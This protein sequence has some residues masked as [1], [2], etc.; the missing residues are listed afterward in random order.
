MA[1]VFIDGFESG[2]GALKDWVIPST[3][4][5]VSSSSG[6]DMSGS[7]CLRLSSLG[8]T[9]CP[10]QDSYSELYTAFK[11]RFTVAS[12]G[13]RPFYFLD[14]DGSHIL[15]I[16]RN[17]KT[18]IFTAVLGNFGGS[19]LATGSIPTL[20]DITYLIEIY[21]KP[22]NSGGVITLRVNGV[23]DF[24][25]TGDVTAGLENDIKYFGFGDKDASYAVGFYVDDIVID[26][27]DWIGETRIQA[28]TVTGA[29]T[30]NQWDA[31][32][33]TNRECVDEI[34]YNDSDYISTNVTNE[35]DTFAMGDLSGS[36]VS[37]KSVQ[38]EARIAYEGAPTPTHIQLGCR[39]GG[40]DYFTD[41]KSPGVSFG[42]VRKMLE[43]NPNGDIPWTESSVN[44]AEFGV[45]AVA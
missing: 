5:D 3:T 30:T 10:L 1:R 31:S 11:I 25:F 39:S 19:T 41:N 16:E 8:E 43:N 33:A 27:S 22:L 29:G 17:Y 20:Y 35:I 24:T 21:Y 18:G 13:R 12:G 26:D 28:V 23:E 37:I 45:K 36:I 9:Y 44:A 7:Y 4:V 38:V 6:L 15:A 32:A 42:L 40:T 14:S 34:P 2:S